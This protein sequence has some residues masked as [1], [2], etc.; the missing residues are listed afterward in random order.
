MCGV[1][2][3]VCVIKERKGVGYKAFV[4]M[5]VSACMCEVL[6]QSRVAVTLKYL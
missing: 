4:H 2:C 3:E 5:D 6:F 1:W